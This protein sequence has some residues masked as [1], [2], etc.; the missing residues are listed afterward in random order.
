MGAGDEAR[1]LSPG[2]IAAHCPAWDRKDLQIFYTLNLTRVGHVAPWSKAQLEVAFGQRSNYIYTAVRGID[3]GTGTAGE[4][5]TA[6]GV[7]GS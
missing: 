2:S 7:P 3:T 1:F 4:H 6:H 5:E